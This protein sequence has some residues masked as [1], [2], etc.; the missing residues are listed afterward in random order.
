MSLEIEAKRN[1]ESTSPTSKSRIQ[2]EDPERFGRPAYDSL[3]ALMHSK[4]H[5]FWGGG[6]NLTS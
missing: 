1:L 3:Q 6:V 4:H 2:P 5:F